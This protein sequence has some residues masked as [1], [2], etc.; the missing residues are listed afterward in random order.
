MEIQ[1]LKLVL[2]EASVNT[3][4]ARL[5]P[6]D[7][8]LENLRLRLLSEGVLA[9]GDYATPLGK[10]AFETLWAP[11]V[12][13]GVVLARLASIKVAGWPA[14]V[15]RGLLLKMIRDHVAAEP[16]VWVENETVRVD[17]QQ[18]L[19]A[20][21]VPLRVR[22]TSVR[23]EGGQIVVEAAPAVGSHPT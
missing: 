10:V 19:Q 2:T 23:C 14:G 5:V 6:P 1:W 21:G 9:Q 20:R 13:E 17:V 18:A 8:A 16:G 3:L 12:E 22:L 11:G 15:L 4:A 7:E